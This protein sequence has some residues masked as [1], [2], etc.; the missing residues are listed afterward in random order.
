MTRRL[1]GA[2]LLALIAATPAAAHIIPQPA[3]L[4]PGEKTTVTFAAPNERPPHTLSKVSITAP[5]GIDLADA[6]PPPGWRLTL[7]GRTAS[8]SR[9]TF[10]VGRQPEVQFQIVAST[11]LAPGTAVLSALQRYDDG[12][13]VSWKVSFTILPAPAA[14]PRQHL[15]P[16]IVTAILGLVV[17]GLLLLR[18]R[19]RRRPDLQED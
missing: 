1:L 17:I 14:T 5:R 18:M 11:S 4:T 3:F 9:A 8:W 6:K 19:D 16:A 12:G 15:L 10:P 7:D 13:V 2:G